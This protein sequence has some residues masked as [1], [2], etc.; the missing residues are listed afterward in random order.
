MALGTGSLIFSLYA[1]RKGHDQ[2]VVDYVD[3]CY[4]G[5]KEQI[6]NLSCVLGGILASEETKRLVIETIPYHHLSDHP[7]EE[8]FQFSSDRNSSKLGEPSSEELSPMSKG[9][10]NTSQ[11]D[12]AVGPSDQRQ[13]NERVQGTIESVKVT[14]PDSTSESLQSLSPSTEIKN[15]SLSNS[16]IDYSESAHPSASHEQSDRH[17]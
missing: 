9:A 11:T 3:F 13:A 5:L 4:P 2:A 7:F 16:I 6:S 17:E 1:L 12:T 15:G 8:L 10:V 14:Q